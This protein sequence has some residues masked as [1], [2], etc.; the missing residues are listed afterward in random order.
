MKVS[1]QT[2]GGA[3]AARKRLLADQVQ[4]NLRAAAQAHADRMKQTAVDLSNGSLSSAALRRAGHPYSVRFGAGAA[5][6]A[7]YIINKQ[8]GTFAAGWQTQVQQTT[9]GWTITLLNVSPEAKYLLGTKK[10]RV[11]PILEEVMRRVQDDL[12]ARTRK[13]TRKAAH[14]HGTGGS[15]LGGFVFAVVAGASAVTG[16]IEH[17]IGD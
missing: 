1:F 5:G 3:L 2:N 17:A 14:D 16:G 8:S 6:Q 10:A 12:P 7:D 9:K 11:R 13:V 4:G 15:A